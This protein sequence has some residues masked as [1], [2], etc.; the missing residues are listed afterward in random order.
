[1]PR[2]RRDVVVDRS[3]CLHHMLGPYG[4]LHR[5]PFQV[6]GSTTTTASTHQHTYYIN[7]SILCI[8]ST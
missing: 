1:M 7:L 2:G 5:H 8:S 3:R 4:Y 6:A